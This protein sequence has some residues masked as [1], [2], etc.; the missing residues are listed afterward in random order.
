LGGHFIF[1]PISS[2][3]NYYS[4]FTTGI[5]LTTPFVLFALIPAVNLI[6]Y[7]GKTV[8]GANKKI[9]YRD[10]WSGDSLFRWTAL[11]LAGGAFLAFAPILVYIAGMMRFLGDVIP[12]LILLSTFGL[13]MS[14]QYLEGKSTSIFWFNFL[15]VV[16]TVYSITISLLL[17]VT[18]A[19][20]R[21][22][23]L[24]PILFDKLTRWFTP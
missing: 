24:N 14:R 20:A 12:L 22:E 10:G 3:S 15:V 2:P 17:A 9:R 18:G 23:H 1:F 5:L 11:S 4:E 8:T 21:F 6:W 7:T 16:L 13:F 19:E